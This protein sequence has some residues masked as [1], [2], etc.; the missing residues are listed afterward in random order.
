M[1]KILTTLGRGLPPVGYRWLGSGELVEKGDLLPVSGREDLGEWIETALHGRR[2]PFPSCYIRK[3][4][5]P[6]PPCF[7]S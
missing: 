6:T 1:S 7:S 2:C 4:N 5:T 3:L